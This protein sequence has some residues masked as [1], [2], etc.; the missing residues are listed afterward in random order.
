MIY[1]SDE[2]SLLILIKDNIICIKI[3]V[4]FKANDEKISYLFIKCKKLREIRSAEE[5]AEA[6]I[7]WYMI[8][9][10]VW[11]I[12]YQESILF[13]DDLLYDMLFCLLIITD[14]SENILIKNNC[15][16]NLY[17]IWNR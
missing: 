2:S 1:K 11:L 14:F 7:N 15:I 9:S 8:W 5:T 13:S 10:D 16:L 17:N 4:I 3:K 12:L 6:E